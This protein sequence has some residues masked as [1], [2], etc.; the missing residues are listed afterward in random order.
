M[1]GRPIE[2]IRPDITS[3]LHLCVSSSASGWD[4]WTGVVEVWTNTWR[5]IHEASHPPPVKVHAPTAEGH[6][7]RYGGGASSWLV[8]LTCVLSWPDTVV[9]SGLAGQPHAGCAVHE[10]HLRGPAMIEHETSD[11]ICSSHQA[12][13][14]PLSMNIPL[15]S[16]I[17]HGFPG[18]G[19]SRACI[20]LQ[21]SP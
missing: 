16:R 11:G 4:E 10:R 3:A 21:K 18:A 20:S 19:A 17:H 13:L 1:R 5:R 9:A 12:S 7:S 15:N 8:R 14:F 2:L 6:G